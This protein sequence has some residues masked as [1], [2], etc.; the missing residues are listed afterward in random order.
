[1]P[2]LTCPERIGREYTL[3]LIQPLQVTVG[4]WRVPGRLELPTLGLDADDKYS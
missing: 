4:K 3:K 1:M 2:K